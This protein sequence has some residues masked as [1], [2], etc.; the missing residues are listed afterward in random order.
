METAQSGYTDGTVLKSFATLGP[1][2]KVVYTGS[3]SINTSITNDNKT[4]ST[5]KPN[6]VER[7]K[8]T[9]DSL[10]DVNAALDKSNTIMDRLYGADRIK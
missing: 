6:I 1:E 4:K 5:K 2:A 8:E 7:Y 3:K 10:N 9:T